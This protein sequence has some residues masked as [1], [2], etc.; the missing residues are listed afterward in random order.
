M[1]MY[2]YTCSKNDLGFDCSRPSWYIQ[3]PNKASFEV[4]T[5]MAWY[6]ATHPSRPVMYPRRSMEG[7]HH[8]HVILT[9]QSLKLLPFLTDSY[10]PWT[11]TMSVSFTTDP[12]VITSKP[13]F[14]VWQLIGNTN[15]QNMLV[16]ILL[17]S[18]EEDS[19]VSK[20][21]CNVAIFIGMPRDSI[22]PTPIC[23]DSQPCIVM[24]LTPI[25]LHQESSTL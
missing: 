16:F 3:S 5:R 23:K 4:L 10:S 14:M 20:D 15:N 24:S 17:I 9:L 19:A 1:L 11:A 2:I 8:V 21:T 6:L 18:T 12:Y 22:H 7:T 13:L 25:P